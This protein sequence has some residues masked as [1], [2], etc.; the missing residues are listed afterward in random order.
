MSDPQ[1]EY[2][3]L[4]TA[5]QLVREAYDVLNAKESAVDIA[6]WSRSARTLLEAHGLAR[7]EASCSSGKL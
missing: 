7:K 1:R 5:L 4:Q 3:R 2:D 6:D